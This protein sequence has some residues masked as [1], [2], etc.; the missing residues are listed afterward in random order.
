MRDIVVYG[1]GGF[2]MEVAFLVEDINKVEHRWNVLGYLDDD[3]TKWGTKRYGYEVLGDQEFL[4]GP[5]PGTAVAV[6]VAAPKIRREIITK[7]STFGVDLPTLVH[8]GV[9]RSRTVSIGEGTIVCAGCILT[10]E[11]RIGKHVHIN[12]ACTIGH[13]AVLEDYVTLYPGVNVAGNVVLRESA[14]LGTG[15]KVVQGLEIGAGSF[16]GA[17]SVAIRP[18]PAHVVAAGCPAQ[19]KSNRSPE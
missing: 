14:S 17:G 9:I 19:V 13:E 5:G 2:G 8:P 11:I 3:S 4:R 16:L 10:V 15:A 12:P 18:I 7:I 1:A 6:A